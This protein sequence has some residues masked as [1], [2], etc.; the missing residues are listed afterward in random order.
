MLGYSKVNSISM[1]YRAQHIVP[2]RMR[3]MEAAIMKKDYQTFA[4]LTMQDSNQF[5]AICL[6]TY[7]PITYMNDTSRKIISLM[8]KYNSLQDEI[9][10]LYIC[11]LGDCTNREF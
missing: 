3:Q 10:V 4:K 2:E 11:S 7:P 6:D 1:Q 9:K 8:T 5:H